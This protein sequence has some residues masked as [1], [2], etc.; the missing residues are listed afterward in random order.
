MCIIYEKPKAIASFVGF[1][2]LHR[3][4][5]K[6]L[7]AKPDFYQESSFSWNFFQID[8]TQFFRKAWLL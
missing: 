2:S 6:S 7:K 3:D 1:F 4:E 8:Y 5:H